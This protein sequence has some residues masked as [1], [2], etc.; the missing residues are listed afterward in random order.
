MKKIITTLLLSIIFIS[1]NNTKSRNTNENE[2]F[3][4]KLGRYDKVFR[5]TIIDSCEYLYADQ[6][7]NG[8]IITHKGN[9]KFCE[10]RKKNQ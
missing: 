7:S 4:T 1:C 6:G 2:I 8:Q 9:C 5:T 10:E 3:T